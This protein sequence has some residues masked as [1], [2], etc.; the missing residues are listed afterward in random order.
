[1]RIFR[2]LLPLALLLILV[3]QFPG[4]PA[5]DT[6]EFQ[7]FTLTLA[8]PKKKYVELQPIPIVITLRNETETTL[9][10]HDALAFDS[11]YLKLSVDTGD[12]PHEI[13]QLSLARSNVIAAPREFKP[14][15][16]VMLTDRLNFKLNEVFPQ[17]GTYKVQA[18]LMSSDRKETVSSKPLEIEIVEPV[19]L[20]AQALEF[21]RNYGNPP[22]FFTGAQVLK[23]YEKFRVLENFVAV[24]GQSAYADDAS[25]LLGQVQFA[26][27]EYQRARPHFEKLSKKSD[28]AFAGEAS[29]YL[30]RI[31]RE[32]KKKDRP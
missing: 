9:E 26:K 2:Y 25:F 27:R 13:R 7:K 21:I 23:N 16:E 5:Q 32:E 11:G 28:Y 29:E 30:K 4:R 15:E 6:G 24:Y 22:F 3:P 1:M 10:G 20:D 12:G 14:G 31:E 17:P 19:G 8:T 18:Q